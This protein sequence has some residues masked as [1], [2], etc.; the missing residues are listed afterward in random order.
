MVC[1]HDVIAAEALNLAQK[2]GLDPRR[3]IDALGKSA[4][5]SATFTNKAPVMLARRFERGPSAFSHMFGYLR[6]ANV[7]RQRGE[8]SHADA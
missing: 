2:A 1:A 4:A 5:G 8:R 3:A 6:C 7:A